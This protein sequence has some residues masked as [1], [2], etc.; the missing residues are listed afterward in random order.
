M[1]MQSCFRALLFF[2]FDLAELFLV[3]SPFALIVFADVSGM[4]NFIVY[5]FCFLKFSPDH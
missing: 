2:L 3:V 5:S 1:K 4:V